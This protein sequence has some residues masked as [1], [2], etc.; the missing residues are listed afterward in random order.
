[1]A[2][3]DRI[4]VHVPYRALRER[5]GLLL[6]NGLHPEIYLAGADL[7]ALL[8]GEGSDLAARLA[9]AG[10]RTTVHGPFADLSPG[11]S[12]RA[13]RDLTLVRMRGALLGA[14]PFRPDAVVFHPGFDPV[15]MREH[16]A[17]WLRNSLRT[18]KAL[19]PPPPALASAWI[20]VEN[21]FERD[22]GSLCALLERLPSPPFGFCLDTGHFRLF[23]EVPLETWLEALGPRLR[24][25]HLH[26]N[27]G[28]AD[29]HLPPG[30]GSFDFPGLFRLLERLDHAV[31]GT[32]EMHREPDIWAGLDYLRAERVL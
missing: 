21:I 27:R 13:F 15:R 8:S 17:L 9:G 28:E 32:L 11:A 19:L 24:E 16:A 2:L 7:P 22:P 6:A 3:F 30:Q 25:V 20:L 12:D 29:E 31:L 23:S 10:L 14:A 18:W 26:D 1:M 5:I 4:Q